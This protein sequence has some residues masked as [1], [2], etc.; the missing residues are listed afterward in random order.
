[1][2]KKKKSWLP[3]GLLTFICIWWIFPILVVLFNSFKKKTWIN[4]QPFTLPD[5]KT[6][7]GLSN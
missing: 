7:T 3:S 5:A 4:Q 1:M 6:F 2:T